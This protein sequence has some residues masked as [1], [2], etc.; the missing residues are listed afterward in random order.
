MSKPPPLSKV[1]FHKA[2]EEQKKAIKNQGDNDAGPFYTEPFKTF[3]EAALSTF[4]ETAEHFMSRKL[5]GRFSDPSDAHIDP[6][7][8]PVIKFNEGVTSL[9]RYSLSQN[10]LKIASDGETDIVY[11]TEDTLKDLGYKTAPDG[12]V[13]S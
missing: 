12:S 6:E 2:S 3:Q 9:L 10:R 13:M 7:A 8:D 1:T 4:G 5:R 11:G